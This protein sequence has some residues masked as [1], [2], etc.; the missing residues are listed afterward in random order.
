VTEKIA[1][2]FLEKSFKIMVSGFVVMSA[3]LIIFIKIQ[4]KNPAFEKT[5]IGITA[6]GAGLWFVGRICVILHQRR[7][8]KQRELAAKEPSGSET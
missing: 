2:F 3:G 5:A 6:C 8:R 7:L 1:A 4:H